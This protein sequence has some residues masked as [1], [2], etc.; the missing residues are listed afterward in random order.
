MVVS[1][2]KIV[3]SNFSPR[4]TQF[5]AD[6]DRIDRLESKL[7]SMGSE[8]KLH[9]ADMERVETVMRVSDEQRAKYARMRLVHEAAWLLI[10]QYEA[11]LA[12]NGLPV[13]YDGEEV[14]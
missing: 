2:F 10:E 14:G 3:M 11:R 4:Q 12:A 8:L 9:A 13:G 6:R 7:E 1:V 5:Y